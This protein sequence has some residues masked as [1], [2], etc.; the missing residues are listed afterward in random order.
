[1]K[2]GVRWQQRF[3][4]FCK[5]LITIEKVIPSHNDLNELE[6][7]GVIQRFEYTFDNAWKVMQDFL[8]EEGFSDINGPRPVI[9]QMAKSNYI[10]P[11]IWSEMLTARNMLS[12]NYSQEMSREYFDKIIN[13]F[14]PA[15]AE[16]KERMEKELE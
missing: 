4:N 7:D 13:D 12:H 5:A 16:F 9:T 10:N 1:M 14:Y 3:D 2:S 8:K 6:I 15:L 11:F